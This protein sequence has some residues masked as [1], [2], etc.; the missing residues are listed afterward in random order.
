MIGLGRTRRVLEAVAKEH[1]II[2]SKADADLF[3]NSGRYPIS[4]LT[5][6][7]FTTFY[8]PDPEPFSEDACAPLPALTLPNRALLQCMKDIISSGRRLYGVPK[9]SLEELRAAKVAKKKAL[10]EAA[11][12]LQEDRKVWKELKTRKDGGEDIEVPE[13]PLSGRQRKKKRKIEA[14]MLE[15]WGDPE[16]PND[17][18][19]STNS[20]EIPTP[21]S[22]LGSLLLEPIDKVS[23]G[24]TAQGWCL[25]IILGF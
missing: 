14:Q 4:V 2:E 21:K 19:P 20:D 16:D 6:D 12:Q 22:E 17:D 15:I 3:P 13:K 1:N 8:I 10:E 9:P 18:Y 7:M 24:C 5:P 25:I 23:I 11:K